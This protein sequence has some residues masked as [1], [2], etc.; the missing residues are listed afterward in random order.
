MDLAMVTA[1]QIEKMFIIILAGVFCEKKRIIDSL[2]NERL[3]HLLLSLIS[4]VL[5]FT[6]YQQEFSAD[7]WNGLLSADRKSV[8]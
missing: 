3:S 5:I 7:K 6:S 4:P 1:A 8:V 2:A